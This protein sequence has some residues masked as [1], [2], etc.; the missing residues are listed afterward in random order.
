M[1]IGNALNVVHRL[2][3]YL[4]GPLERD[5]IENKTGSYDG[6]FILDDQEKVRW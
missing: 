5:D 2:W 4:D 6:F 1:V 3:N